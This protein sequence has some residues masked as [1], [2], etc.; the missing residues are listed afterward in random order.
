MK[1]RMAV[2]RSVTLVSAAT[3]V[4]YAL[5]L[6]VSIW[7]AR[8]LGPADFGRYAF[9]VWLCSWLMTCSNHALTTSSTKF[10]AE[11]DGA[12]RPD[13]A[14]HIAHR[15]SRYQHL[16]SFIVV[17]LFVAGTLVI[18]PVEWRQSLLP[19]TLL[20][21][22][23]VV[24]KAN[25][26]M[27]VA[28]EKGQESFEPVSIATV[29]SGVIGVGLIG[30]A[31]AVHAGMVT[32]FALFAVACL[33]LNLI[34]RLAF[35]RYCRPFSAGP[36]PEDIRKRLSRHLRL[37]A[38]L[39]LLISLKSSTIEVFLL[40]T[41]ATSTA[42]GFFAIAATLTRGAVELLS[43]GLTT[44]LLPYM[45]KSFGKNGTGQ[46]A[47]LLTEATRFYWATGLVIAGLGLVTTPEIVRLMYG[48]RYVDAIPVIETTLVLAGLLLIGNSIAAFQ[49]VVDRQDDRVRISVLALIVN[50]VLGVALVPFFGLAGAVLTYAGTRFA[51]LGLAIFYLRRATSG[52]LPIAQM[53]RLFGIATAA[54]ASAWLCVAMIPSRFGFLAG[55]MVFLAIFVPAS[56]LVRYWSDD[57]YRLMTMITDR[58]GPPG[59]TLMRGLSILHGPA[60]KAP[61]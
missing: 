16:S 42:V 32:F 5:G 6:V 38:A 39:V 44:T 12:G 26:A 33:M 59:R 14:S 41:Y 57:D 10:I 52:G 53:A 34:N 25:Y 31:T 22:V 29:L 28:I 19:V 20:V 54:T 35:H 43:V 3:Y 46:A 47:R 56:F 30:A 7:I 21:I 60:A 11:A 13:I 45:A 24:A 58:L 49:I 36:I 18:R 51:E 2:L 37:T 40:N 27:L 61:S 55:G 50:A 17:L 1:Q 8:T 9:T 23:A 48:N 4:E 15:L